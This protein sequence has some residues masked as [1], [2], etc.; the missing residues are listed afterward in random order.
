MDHTNTSPVDGI[1]L[2]DTVGRDHVCSPH[3][4]RS[5]SGFCLR[6]MQQLLNALVHLPIVH[7]KIHLF[8]L[9]SQ[10]MRCTLILARN[11]YQLFQSYSRLMSE[12]TNKSVKTFSVR[13]GGITDSGRDC[14]YSHHHSREIPWHYPVQ[15]VLDDLSWTP[16]LWPIVLE[17]SAAIRIERL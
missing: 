5:E 17:L 8:S 7:N 15:R 6:I 14:R 13:C 4:Q 10:R 9:G 12:I 16:L 11:P 3:L 2:V 1:S